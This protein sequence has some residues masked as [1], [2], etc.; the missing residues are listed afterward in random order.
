M[1]VAHSCSLC[2]LNISHHPIVDGIHCFCCPGCQAVFQI[3]TSKNQLNNFQEHP[4]FQQAVK[5]GL[6]SN[7]LLLEQLRAKSLSV[8]KCEQEKLHLDI[9]D[10]WCPSCAEI[11]QW[12][13]GQEQG[14]LRCIVD[15]ATDI[16]VIE[17]APREISKERIM[18]TIRTLG[19]RPAP[20]QSA[21][22]PAV[23]FKLY[24]GFLIAA[25]FSLN[26]MMFAYPLYAT[27]FNYD[28]Q[29]VGS[30]FAWLSF[31]ASLPVI[32]YS[33]W[34]IWKRA[35][36]GLKMGMPGM[37]FLVCMGVLAA[38][39][40]SVYD[41]VNGGT[42]VYF[43]SMT[44]IIAF[45]LLGK[46]MESKAKW[47]AKDSLLRLSRGLPRRG[48]RRNADGEPSYVPIKEIQLGD[49]LIALSGEKII[50]DGVVLEGKGTCDE[51][52]MTGE[53]MPMV[54]EPGS[55]VLGGTI[56]QNGW[57]AFKVTATAE[58]S[59]LQRI[60][61]MI[62]QEIERKTH[63]VRITDPLV[64]WF[65]PVVMIVAALAGICAGSIHEGILRTV[66]VLLISCPCAIGIAAPLAEAHLMN[67]LAKLGVIVRNRGALN[68]L[69]RETVFVFDKTGT[70]T[71][72]R[73]RMLEGAEE[74]SEEERAILKGLVR[75]STHPIA[76]AIEEALAL[77][78]APLT[79]I[80]EVAGQGLKGYYAGT[81]YYL[82]SEE[83]IRRQGIDLTCRQ[84]TGANTVVYF[85]AKGLV[86]GDT[87]RAGVPALIAQLQPAQSLLLSGDSQATVEIIGQACGFTQCFWRRSPLAKRE[88]IEDLRNKG[89]IVCMVGDGINDAPALTAA[90][91]GIS[92]V[93]ASDISIQV[94]DLL[95]T[96]DR[97]E[98]IAKIM[99]LA[100][101]GRRVIYQ[102]LFWAFFYN[103]I[104][105]GLAA[106]G[107]L[108]P[109]FAATAMVLSSFMVLF[110]AQRLSKVVVE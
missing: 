11:I 41:L 100:R 52:I 110:N 25:F 3:L 19:Y 56:V 45:V 94:S 103:I 68:Y 89:E 76:C 81:P 24:M 75:H 82:G 73:F 28:D 12:V 109:I 59:A 1:T 91:V 5:A 57:M 70:V 92:V 72:G 88:A 31:W 44:V 96:T 10:M 32:T 6:I 106:F 36:L 95:L 50:L 102:N 83:F 23:N 9:Q 69:G 40:L 27:Y 61:H 39:G 21:D 85:C 7:P 86:L 80:E 18:D 35:W 93:S 60:I 34:P 2:N 108:T 63:Y 4:L 55:L 79:S 38:F 64:R 48:R 22:Q 99:A 14:I 107:L 105:I 29:G 8:P 46:I 62:E 43:D 77:P 97:I 65:V 66:A 54:K 90:H 49:V 98:V 101:K 104:G 84:S 26:I 13:V 42:K 51:S 67:G 78:A 74:L 37:E 47:K 30:L 15:Y 71:E 33:A 53:A 58:A 20:L 87:I 17:F 16:A